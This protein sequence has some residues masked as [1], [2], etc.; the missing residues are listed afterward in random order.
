MSDTVYCNTSVLYSRENCDVFTVIRC[1]SSNTLQKY[2]KNY[3]IYLNFCWE[4]FIKSIRLFPTHID[5]KEFF[6]TSWS[7][8]SPN[9]SCSVIEI[10]SESLKDSQC[11][12]SWK[13]QQ[14]RSSASPCRGRHSASSV[15]SSPDLYFYSNRVHVHVHVL[16]NYIHKSSLVSAL[17]L[18]HLWHLHLTPPGGDSEWVCT[19]SP[20]SSSS[21]TKEPTLES[22]PCLPDTISL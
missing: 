20:S 17:P 3:L 21:G 2:N 10:Q 8:L 12:L 18:L 11:V 19:P 4:M 15:S 1:H 14:R 9:V 5:H 7:I 16:H 13:Q 22:C 6:S